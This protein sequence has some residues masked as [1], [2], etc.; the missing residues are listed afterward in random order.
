VPA[1]RPHRQVAVWRPADRAHP[2]S[3]VEAEAPAAA[4]SCTPVASGGRK[5]RP[6]ARHQSTLRL[7]GSKRHRS[8]KYPGW[9]TFM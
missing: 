6:S 5:S 8:R 9:S 7:G 3:R 1:P 4:Q 2:L